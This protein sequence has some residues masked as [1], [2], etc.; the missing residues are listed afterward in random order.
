MHNHM[1]HIQ[2]MQTWVCLI[3]SVWRGRR[4]ECVA[5]ECPPL[6]PSLVQYQIQAIVPKVCLSGSGRW[7][8]LDMQRSSRLHWNPV[9]IIQ[10]SSHSTM[11]EATA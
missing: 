11:Q 7:V 2:V 10:A 4:W 1:S 8:Y 5:C 6:A 9:N 3:R